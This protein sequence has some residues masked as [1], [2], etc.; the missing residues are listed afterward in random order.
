MLSHLDL[1]SGKDEDVADQ[2]TLKEQMDPMKTSAQDQTGVSL[3]ATC[4]SQRLRALSSLLANGT[5]ASYSDTHKLA[6]Y[7]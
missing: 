1:C 2:A 5:S 4:L 6:A 3:L 7:F